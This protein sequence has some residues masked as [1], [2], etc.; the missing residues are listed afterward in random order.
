LVADGRAPYV[1]VA[2]IAVIYAATA[3]WSDGLGYGGDSFSHYLISRYSWR[4]PELFLDGWGKPFFTLVSSP[5]TQLGWP[6]MIAFNAVTG[7]L[8][9]HVTYLYCRRLGM[10][11]SAMSM[12]SWASCRFICGRSRPG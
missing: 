10:P 2:A 3:A 9:A 11:Y 7:V 5:F 8:T 4:H 12:C 6:G 1:L